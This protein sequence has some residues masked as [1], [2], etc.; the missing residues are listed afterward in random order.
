MVE[1]SASIF[2][3]GVVKYSTFAWRKICR[4][5]RKMQRLELG[6]DR[7]VAALRVSSM[8]RT[9]SGFFLVGYQLFMED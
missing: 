2:S 3:V 9:L 1:E 4:G 6:Q 7:K 8:L 5:I